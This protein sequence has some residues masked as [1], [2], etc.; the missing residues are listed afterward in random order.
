MKKPLKPLTGEA[1]WKLI[2]ETASRVDTWPDWKKGEPV[3]RSIM[4]T[5]ALN[6]LRPE[7]GNVTLSEVEMIDH[8]LMWNDRLVARLWE[9][10]GRKVSKSMGEIAYE[11]YVASTGGVSAVSGEKL[12]P[13]AKTNQKVQLAWHAA[14]KAVVEEIQKVINVR[15]P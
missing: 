6:P 10:E 1:Y 9:V 5:T 4:P 15:E 3:R 2:R 11:A 14:A 8:L 7:E 13:F 12:P